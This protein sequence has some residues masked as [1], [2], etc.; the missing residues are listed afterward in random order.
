MTLATAAYLPFAVLYWSKIDWKYWKYYAIVSLSGSAIPNFIFAVAQQHVSSSLAGVLNSLTP[1]FTLILGAAFFQLPLTR[2]KVLGVGLGFVG[3]CVLVLLNAQSA[4]Q[5]NFGYA[6]LCAFA[7][8]F[9]AINS[10]VVGK[11]LAG[12]HPAALASAAFLLMGIPF[13]IA[14]FWSGGWDA[15]F[16]HPDGL[17][18]IGY[19][20][21]LAVVGTTLSSFLY[22]ALLQ[23]TGPIFGT[24]VT[25]LLPI[26]TL[27][28]GSLDGEAIGIWELVGTGVILSG[29]YLARKR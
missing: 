8:I 16:S 19:L 22:F 4:V 1:L 18:G 12:Q 7:T 3:A 15:A 24:S 25:F 26:M 17:K 6:V 9:Y 21:V 20:S 10:N 14:L 28:V 27:I 5:G 29:L 11:Y 23:R 2:N 13:L